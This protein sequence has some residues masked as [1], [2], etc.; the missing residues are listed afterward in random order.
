MSTEDDS[1]YA[2][3]SF[4]RR[5]RPSGNSLVI[6]IPPKVL[7]GAGLAEGDDIEV[8]AKADGSI[9]LSPAEGDD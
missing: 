5:I 3:V 1:A 4:D 6:S 9:I 8:V 2:K 7:R